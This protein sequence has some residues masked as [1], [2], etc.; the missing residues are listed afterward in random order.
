ME[1]AVGCM[2]QISRTHSQQSLSS[3]F[4][5][6]IVEA[7]KVCCVIQLDWSR[8]GILAV[9]AREVVSVPESRCVATV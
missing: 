8:E 9:I 3:T 2:R 5:E 6:R 7:K 4:T 1:T